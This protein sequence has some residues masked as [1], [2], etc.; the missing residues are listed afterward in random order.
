M[1]VAGFVRRRQKGVIVALIALSTV[2]T[3]TVAWSYYSSQRE[4]AAEARLAQVIHAYNQARINKSGKEGFEPIVVEARKIRDEYGSSRSSRLA[5][6]YQA[7]SEESLGHTDRCVQSLQE[8]IREGDPT[9]KPLALFALAGLY[10]NH[11]DT[12]KAMAIHKELEESGGYSRH[13]THAR[14]GG[15]P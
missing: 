3:T 6:Y 15:R 14:S 11:G 5:H 4:A 12:Q 2:V 9:M 7:M 1:I 8:L 13:G 10:R